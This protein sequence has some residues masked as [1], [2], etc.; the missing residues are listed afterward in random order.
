MARL[1]FVEPGVDS[2][3][4]WLLQHGADKVHCDL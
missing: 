2:Y 4:A 3:N 1:K